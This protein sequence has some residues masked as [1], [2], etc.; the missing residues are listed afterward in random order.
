MYLRARPSVQVRNE[1]SIVTTR[2]H[3]TSKGIRYEARVRAPDGRERC[4][5][6]A[7][8][9]EALDWEAEQRAARAGGLW[10]DPRGAVTPFS[11]WARRWLDDDLAKSPGA[12]STDGMIIRT[13]LM[14]GACIPALGG[15]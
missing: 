6:F 12:R 8:R 10:V 13:H 1:R 2:K 7:T 4:R 15:G 14:P 3:M 11:E 9:R 5:W